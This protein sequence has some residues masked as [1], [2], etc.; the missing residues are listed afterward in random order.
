MRFLGRVI[1][2]LW[3]EPVLFLVVVVCTAV[4]GIVVYVNV[5]VETITLQKSE[6][7]CTASEWITTITLVPAGK[8]LIPLSSPSKQCTEWKRRAPR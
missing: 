4:I 3:D 2:F 7:E 1:D 5:T 8:A 6:W